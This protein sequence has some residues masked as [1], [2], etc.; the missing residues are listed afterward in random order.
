[1]P[2]GV[3]VFSL[4]LDGALC[5]KNVESN[6]IHRH[7]DPRGSLSGV[8]EGERWRRG[9]T[10]RGVGLRLNRTY[11]LCLSAGSRS[12]CEMGRE[13]DSTSGSTTFLFSS[14][15]FMELAKLKMAG[16]NETKQS[17]LNLPMSLNSF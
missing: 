11:M 1:M 15:T 9:K 6:V 3:S 13:K 14:A 4:G 17:A 8:E 10:T 2:V 12:D 16:L 7:G 5:S